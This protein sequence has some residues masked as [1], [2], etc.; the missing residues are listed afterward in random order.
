MIRV[1]GILVRMAAVGYAFCHSEFYRRRQE[2]NW[3]TR[4][5]LLEKALRLHLCSR[6]RPIRHFGP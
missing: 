6:L 2:L 5:Y 3:T 1:A 4:N